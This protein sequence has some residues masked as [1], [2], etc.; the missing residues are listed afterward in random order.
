M[1]EKERFEQLIKRFPELNLIEED[2]I[3]VLKN[4]AYFATIPVGREI[5]YPGDNVS[6]IALLLS[7]TVR[8][9]KMSDTGREITLYRFF[10]G[11]SCILTANAILNSQPFSAILAQGIQVDLFSGQAGVTMAVLFASPLGLSDVDPIGGSV[12]NALKAGGVD[13]TL[14]QPGANSVALLPVGG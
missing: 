14:Q 2:M 6:A 13:K 4:E 12:A 7:G 5:F 3:K 8:V 10:A 9:Y 1:L 11:E